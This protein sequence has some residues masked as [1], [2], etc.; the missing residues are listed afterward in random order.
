[1]GMTLSCNQVATR[2]RHHRIA[3]PRTPWFDWQP[4]TGPMQPSP[5]GVLQ[6]DKLCAVLRQWSFGPCWPGCL[7]LA[8]ED[9]LRSLCYD[10]CQQCDVQSGTLLPPKSRTPNCRHRDDGFLSS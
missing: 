7:L 9:V 1:M 4:R 8:F 10:D 5:W 3:A 2:V 6:M